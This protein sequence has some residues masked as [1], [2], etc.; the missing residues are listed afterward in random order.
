MPIPPSTLVRAAFLLPLGVASA[1]GGGG[2]SALRLAPRITLALVGP[3]LTDAATLTISGS[4][5]SSAPILSVTSGSSFGSSVDG[6]A[7][8]GLAVPL[9]IGDN[10][11][12]V[13][14]LDLRG[15]TAAV[16]SPKIRRETPLLHLCNEV[17]ANASTALGVAVVCFAPEELLLVD[18]K[19][20]ERTVISGPTRGAGP[21]F[22]GLTDLA[23]ADDGSRLFVGSLNPSAL[24]VVD[25]ATG[26]RTRFLRGT[27]FTDGMVHDAA[28]DRVAFTR[29]FFAQQV[30]VQSLATGTESVL[31]DG[32]D[33]NS[34]PLG[35]PHGIGFDPDSDSF[36]VVD[37]VA[38]APA[39]LRID[40][41]SGKRKVL[42]D[43]D[44]PAQG[45]VPDHPFAIAIDAAG[46]RAFLF[47]DGVGDILEVDLD[48]GARKVAFEYQEIAGLPS[49][50][51]G[52]DL[53]YDATQ[54]ELLV[55]NLDQ[56]MVYDLEKGTRFVRG[57]ANVGSGSALGRMAWIAPD[58][59]KRRL[60]VGDDQTN[61]DAIDLR[62]GD[63]TRLIDAFDNPFQTFVADLEVD[64]RDDA[65]IA[66]DP[67]FTR[68]TEVDGE[69]LRATTLSDS[70]HGGGPPLSRPGRLALDS[71]GRRVFVLDDFG[72]RI[73][74]I[75]L[76][77][78]DRSVLASN[79][80]GLSPPLAALATIDWDP[81]AQRVLV[82][83]LTQPGVIVIDP[84]TGQRTAFADVPDVS[85]PDVPRPTATFLDAEGRSLFV[86]ASAFPF[87]PLIRVDLDDGSRELIA[88]D[89]VGVGF[90]L[91]DILALSGDPS[92]GR[93]WLGAAQLHA[94]VQL[95]PVSG[96]RVAISR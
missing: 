29:S 2:S 46:R 38:A 79:V 36:I 28:R 16:T 76:A 93:L 67:A 34:P 4:I 35:L 1:C 86:V 50:T 71:S 25:V 75:D 15:R 82:I 47:D 65:L 31:T 84:A 17:A 30:R 56:V 72:R 23:V 70:T 14:A 87:S 69:T 10:A 92:T 32:A 80:D 3:S 13:S 73:I 27:S 9:A 40:A 90:P 59:G 91:A 41:D 88:S 53:A 39:V 74:A 12:Q 77:T 11:L 63:R 6:F 19:S 52:L 54:D 45:P 66:T 43:L 7:T 78:G 55:G 68:L 58:L 96:D 57:T 44:D 89:S 60:L 33:G 22:G 24:F 49:S 8:F 85:M 83:D 48:N 94:L 51:F 21:A 81:V 61:L 20:G 37:G 42:S 62:T 64:P 95:D 26:D 5:E 18:R